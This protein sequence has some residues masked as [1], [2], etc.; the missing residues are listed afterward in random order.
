MLV[1]APAEATIYFRESEGV[2]HVSGSFDPGDETLF[3]EFLAR[4]RTK[5]LAVIFLDSAGGAIGPGIA[6]GRMIRK[7]R[8][9][10]AV[11]AGS[12]RCESACTLIFAGGVRR[13]YIGGE[14][15]FEGTS[16]RGGLGYHPAHWRDPSWTRAG[17]SDKGTAQMAAFYREMGQPRAAELMMKAGF[18]SMFRPS[19]QTALALRIATTL[20]AP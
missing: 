17:F 16:G 1:T 3:A 7:A 5:R 12:S 20:A 6:I 19:G 14:A 4:P 13:H 2:A 10:T 11:D 8:L 18:S 9:A 15:I